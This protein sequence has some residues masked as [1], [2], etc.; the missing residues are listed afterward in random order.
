M[1]T[2]LARRALGRLQ[3]ES[4]PAVARLRSLPSILCYHRVAE[5][6]EDPWALCVTPEHFEAQMTVLRRSGRPCLGMTELWDGLHAGSLPRGA[7]V[8]TFDDGYLDNL[9][10]A[11]PILERTGVPATVF[12]TTDAVGTDGT[13]WWD[14]LT[15][16]LL[17][18][19]PTGTLDLPAIGLACELAELA[20]NAT[21][22][23][24]RVQETEPP[25]ARHDAYL[26][27]WRRLAQADDETRRTVLADL[28]AQLGGSARRRLMMDEAQVRT[29]AG[30]ELVEI[31][32][33]TVTHPS[34]PTLCRD[35]LRFELATGKERL[36]AMIGREVR[37]LAY[38]F[39]HHDDA[40]VAGARAAGFDLAVT[41]SGGSIRH[42]T[43][44]L[45]LPRRT[46]IDAAPAAFAAYVRRMG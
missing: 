20:A 14:E 40:T 32:A 12:V 2:T 45:R 36:E 39:G 18:P 13:M 17:T 46:I 41:T 26:R 38:P 19:G 43:D 5:E 21:R 34:L 9:T 7:I 33:H 8:V 25:T 31:G 23:P 28:R 6:Q 22:P 11:L 3:R 10:A 44:P 35:D 15:D 16:L 42:G 4:V 1:P 37:W 27:L 29:L 24:W 30:H